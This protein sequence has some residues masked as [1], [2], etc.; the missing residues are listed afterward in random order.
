MIS[1]ILLGPTV[2][3]KKSQPIIAA[4]TIDVSRSTAA[5]PTLSSLVASMIEPKLKKAIKPPI[6]PLGIK[7]FSSPY[8]IDSFD[9]KNTNIGMAIPSIRKNQAKKVNGLAVARIP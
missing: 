6:I 7:L 9:L 1:D 4:K 2:S 3:F 8:R 5:S